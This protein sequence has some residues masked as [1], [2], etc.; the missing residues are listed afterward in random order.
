MSPLISGLAARGIQ[1]AV[2]VALKVLPRHALD[3]EEK[4]VTVETLMIPTSV[5]PAR[6][7]VYRHPDAGDDAPVHVNFHGGGFIMRGIELDDFWCRFLAARARVVVLNVDYVVAPQHPFPQPVQQTFEV[8]A[9]AAANG[10]THRWNGSR[11]TIGGQSAGGSFSAAIARRSLEEGG[12]RIALQVLHYPVLDLITP[13]LEKRSPL[14]N[15]TLKPWMAEVFDNSYAPNVADRSHRFISPAHPSET[16]DLTGIANAVVITAEFDRLRDE[17]RRY[18]ERLK[19]HSA[20]VEAI[21]LL[22]AD[23]GYDLKNVTLAREVFGKVAAHIER[24]TRS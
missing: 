9:Y 4:R 7:L 11:L 20:L 24:A 8:V 5:K 19:R 15:P 17:A 3:A 16:G 22:G 13:V 2:S 1:A 12:P 23:H 18:A 10:S 6:V 21:D 14:A